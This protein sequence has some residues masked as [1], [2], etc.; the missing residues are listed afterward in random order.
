MMKRIIKRIKDRLYTFLVLKNSAISAE[1]Q[2]YVNADTERHAKHRMKSWIYLL[3]LNWKYRVLKDKKSQLSSIDSV[4]NLKNNINTPFV[5][6]ESSLSARL[7]PIMLAKN[8][9]KYD[10]ISFDIFDTLILRSL[11]NPKDV[12]ALISEE[13]LWIKFKEHRVRAEQEARKI[14]QKKYGVREVNIND[15]YK[16]VNRKTGINSDEG[17]KI[18]FEIE[19]KICYANPYMLEVIRFLQEQNKTIVCTSDMYWP[20]DFL[21]KLLKKVG[22]NDFDNIFVSCDYMVGKAEGLLFEKIKDI[23]GYDA[24]YIHIGDNYN[25]DILGAQKANI[26]SYFYKGVNTIGELHRT[27]GIS[28]LFQSAYN[29]TV[30]ARLHK[31]NNIYSPQYEFGY[32][33]G[34]WYIF[35]FINYI[36][37]YCKKNNIDNILFIAR[38]G[39]IYKQIANIL[40]DNNNIKKNYLL[41]S[42]ICN[43]K[44]AIKFDRDFFLNRVCRQQIKIHR[45]IEDILDSF[46]LSFLK[47]S[48]PKYQLKRTLSN[49]NIEYFENFLIDNIE[50]IEY[51]YTKT[52][53]QLKE[54]FKYLIG[55]S[56]KILLVDIGWV[57]TAPINIKKIIRDE[58]KIDVDIDIILAASHAYIGYCGI[59]SHLSQYLF[60]DNHGKYNRM[61]HSSAHTAIFELLTQST[62][63]SFYGLSDNENNRTSLLFQLPDIE[64][65]FMTAEIQKGIIDFTKD[66]MKNFKHFKYLYNISGQDAYIP[67]RFLMSNKEAIKSLVGNAVQQIYL[68][69]RKINTYTYKSINN[70]VGKNI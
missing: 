67:F 50:T 11:S 65:Y 16:E 34:G 23:Y 43:I 22:Y 13:K 21:A 27:K 9:L 66:Y 51:F 62:T 39:D 47:N 59:N 37:S 44:Y 70:I 30:N 20:K 45:T 57:G 4:K 28:P 31:D 61:V 64:N 55:D 53:L 1:Y 42:R 63:P 12:F 10:V 3:K 5:G 32:I 15:I 19:Q 35:G 60:S 29:A 68:T 46:D 52:E 25:A 38:D 14:A 54:Y 56:K 26:N 33:Y 7:E 2:A 18:E 58:W 49:D 48:L 69:G 40:D 41:W 36:M 17:I 6:S 24:S 8:L